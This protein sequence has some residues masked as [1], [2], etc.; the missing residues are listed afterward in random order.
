[1]K[2]LIHLEKTKTPFPEKDKIY[3]TWKMHILVT[4]KNGPYLGS[5]SGSGARIQ[6]GQRRW[7]KTEA[8]AL[9]VIVTLP[10]LSKWIDM[11]EGG[12]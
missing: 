11:R 6:V 2:K 8:F 10:H 3:V 1:L 7:Q 12:G 9:L 5:G 4:W